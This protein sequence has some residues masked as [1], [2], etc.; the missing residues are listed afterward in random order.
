MNASKTVYTEAD[1]KQLEISIDALIATVEKLVNERAHL[2]KNAEVVKERV[3]AIIS[4][5]KSLELDA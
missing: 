2:I 3:E 5:L 4:R 1:L